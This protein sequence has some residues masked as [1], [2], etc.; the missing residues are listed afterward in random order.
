MTR[1]KQFLPGTV[2]ADV[3]Q[4]DVDMQ[5]INN[6]SIGNGPLAGR[7]LNYNLHLVNFDW[8]TWHNYEWDNW[9]AVDALLQTAI[10]YLNIKGIWQPTTEYLANQA[11]YDPDDIS[12]L[13]KCTTT[14]TSGTS[15]PVDKDLYWQSI[16]APDIAVTSVF[17]RTG[18]VL[19]QQADYDTFFFTK[20]ET[21]ARTDLYTRVEVDQSQGA[22]DANISA[23]STQLNSYYTKTEADNKFLTQAQV[24][25]LAYPVGS[26]YISFNAANPST[27]FPGTT[28]V[29]AG[30][31]RVL[32]GVGNNGT[33]TWTAK[34][35]R[36]AETHTLSQAEMPFHN[37]FVDPPA[38]YFE[39]TTNGQH[40]HYGNFGYLSSGTGSPTGNLV[41]IDI[42]SGSKDKA[43]VNIP[44]AG[45]HIHG[46]TVDIFGFGSG[47]AGSSGAH[48]NIQPSIGAYMWERTA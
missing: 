48:N 12:M 37:H 29:A 13:Y 3:P 6:A 33:S 9:V 22:Q 4:T 24:I 28:W 21:Y 2:G 32:V 10:G 20:N 42:N 34:Q 43:N 15:F 26:I 19:P 39:T 16:D 25:N 45:N 1:K 35:I 17:G 23:L 5:K 38:Q 41:S 47:S 18:S 44:E 46:V 31:G 7:T 27:L 8:V 11:V 30:A 14:H 36:G 40:G